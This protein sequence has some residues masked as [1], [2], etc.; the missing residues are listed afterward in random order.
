MKVRLAAVPE[1]GEANEELVRFLAKILG[2]GIS[3]VILIRGDKSRHKMI[4][5]K[6]VP[7]AKI[8]VQKIADFFIVDSWISFNRQMRESL[9]RLK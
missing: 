5:V 2:I 4:C 1:K 9:L 7:L 6:G 8:Q 3:N